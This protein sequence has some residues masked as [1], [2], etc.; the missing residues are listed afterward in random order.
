MKRWVKIVSSSQS[1]TLMESRWIDFTAK[2]QVSDNGVNGDKLSI[3]RMIQDDFAR[4]R[5]HINEMI[6]SKGVLLTWIQFRNYKNSWQFG[7]IPGIRDFNEI[8][9]YSI[10]NIKR[11]NNDS[12]LQKLYR[13]STCD[14]A[15][16][17][18]ML[19]TISIIL[20]YQPQMCFLTCSWT[21]WTCSA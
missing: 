16:L 7:D 12:M 10:F 11:N 1:G 17:S 5:R 21:F 13:L 9:I 3:N 2:L 15:H 20:V 19:P 8:T 6:L 14:L 4:L 18:T